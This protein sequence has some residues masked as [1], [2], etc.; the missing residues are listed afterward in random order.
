MKQSEAQK[1]FSDYLDILGIKRQY[2]PQA[3]R[4]NILQTQKETYPV[5]TS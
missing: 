1:H 4:Q 3:E 5:V 2:Q